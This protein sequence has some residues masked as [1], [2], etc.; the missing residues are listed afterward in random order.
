M[1]IP[2]FF[3]FLFLLFKN[4]SRCPKKTII[5]FC[6]QAEVWVLRIE[7][8]GHFWIW[9]FGGGFLQKTPQL[10]FTSKKELKIENEWKYHQNLMLG[11]K[12]LKN[13]FGG[14]NVHCLPTVVNLWFQ[15]N[16]NQAKYCKKWS[17]FHQKLKKYKISKWIKISF[18][19][20]FEV[21][22]SVLRP[23]WVSY[24]Q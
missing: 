4:F 14:Q 12:F 5:V 8:F 19:L 6:G 10:W 17:I 11:L 21:F 9:L 22:K 1:L 18:Y 23:L 7:E 16:S 15:K 2:Y 20:F 3:R 13:N 24:D